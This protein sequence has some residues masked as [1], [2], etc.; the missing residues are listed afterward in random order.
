MLWG[1]AQATRPQT[2][3]D[4]SVCSA[5]VCQNAARIH[6]RRSPFPVPSPNRTDSRHVTLT[7]PPSTLR[8]GQVVVKFW[9]QSMQQTTNQ[10]L[11]PPT[12]I[13]SKH[14]GSDTTVE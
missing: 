1:G 12:T 6:P 7:S 8:S 13:R 2:E 9:S 14:E 3:D 5:N 4:S 11:T 10:Y